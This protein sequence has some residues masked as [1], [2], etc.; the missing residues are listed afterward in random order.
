MPNPQNN[1]TS[2]SEER[3]RSDIILLPGRGRGRT[4]KGNITKAYSQLTPTAVKDRVGELLLM[5][6]EPTIAEPGKHTMDPHPAYFGPPV[7]DDVVKMLLGDDGSTMKGGA[8]LMSLVA[9]LHQRIVKIN[10]RFPKRD[11]YKDRG[12]IF[13]KNFE[14]AVLATPPDLVKIV[15]YIHQVGVLDKDPRAVPPWYA[16]WY[17][18]QRFPAPPPEILLLPEESAIATIDIAGSDDDEDENTPPAAGF[19]ASA[20]STE[21]GPKIKQKEE[22]RI[23]DNGDS[24]MYADKRVAKEFDGKIYHGT[25]VNFTA[26]TEG[27]GDLWRIQYDDGDEEDLDLEELQAVLKLFESEEAKSAPLGPICDEDVAYDL[28]PDGSQEMEENSDDEGK[29]KAAKKRSGHHDR[30]ECVLY[31]N[32][33]RNPN[34]NG[35]NNVDGKALSLKKVKEKK[36]YEN[37]LADHSDIG[38][39][40]SH[41]DSFRGHCKKYREDENFRKLVDDRWNEHQGIAVAAGTAGA[42]SV[43]ASSDRDSKRVRRE[44]IDGANGCQN[45]ITVDKKEVWKGYLC[46]GKGDTDPTGGWKPTTKLGR[47]RADALDWIKLKRSGKIRRLD[48]YFT[49]KKAKGRPN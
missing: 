41:S 48:S 8:E 26:G 35:T 14:A 38:T 39:L 10:D 22:A 7:A 30:L 36:G 32:A 43:A 6:Q 18:T 2:S 34:F 5:K 16:E 15:V 29:G 20:S 9:D 21:E 25:V 28:H 3:V 4:V 49:M 1:K 11:H 19:S 27:G 31:C 40:K 45:T 24:Y 46:D 13:R 17:N 42:T 37:T 12:G 33:L 44:V 47:P 23:L